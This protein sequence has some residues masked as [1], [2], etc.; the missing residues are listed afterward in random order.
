MGD[1]YSLIFARY[2]D[3]ITIEPEND[4]FAS[5]SIFNTANEISLSKVCGP[6]EKDHYSVLKNF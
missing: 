5:K 1:Q 4:E 6:Y 3:R 2:K